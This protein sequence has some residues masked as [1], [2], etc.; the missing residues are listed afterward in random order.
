MENS[1]EVFKKPEANTGSAFSFRGF[2]PERNHA[3]KWCTLP[4]VPCSTVYVDWDTEARKMPI[5]SCMEKEDV[6]YRYVY[7]NIYT[8]S[9]TIHTYMHTHANSEG[10]SRWLSSKNLPA[11]QETH[12]TWVWSLGWEDP[13]EEGMATHS[14]ILA[15][16]MP[17]TEEPGRLPSVGSQ[18]VRYD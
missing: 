5:I 8:H 18:R 15:W 3:L 16:R 6:A 14:S 4:S 2:H 1:I 9:H 17:R 7:I 13:L 11:V 10:L 12:E